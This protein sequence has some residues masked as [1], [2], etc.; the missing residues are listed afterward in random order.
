MVYQMLI[1]KLPFVH[2]NPGAMVMA[3]LMQP[4]PDP[5]T[6]I[7]DMGETSAKAIMRALAKQPKERFST[8]GEFV[9]ALADNT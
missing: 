4:P 8:A 6:V 5:R 2:N 7:S 1:G 3:H 9:L